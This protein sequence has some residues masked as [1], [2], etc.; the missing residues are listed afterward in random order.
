MG[1]ER[2]IGSE[3]PRPL[4]PLWDTRWGAG[5][6][7]RHG[8]SSGM[9]QTEWDAPFLLQLLG[10]GEVNLSGNSELLQLCTSQWLGRDAVFSREMCLLVHKPR[11]VADAITAPSLTLILLTHPPSISL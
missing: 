4:R 10:A 8:H 7:A 2:G 1:Q 5:Q 3:P 9:C 11:E 6:A